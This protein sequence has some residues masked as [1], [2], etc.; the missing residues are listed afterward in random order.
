MGMCINGD[1]E[2]VSVK[3]A[4]DLGAEG[5]E[6]WKD[7]QIDSCIASLVAAL[8]RGGVDMRGSCCG[9]GRENGSIVLQDGRVLLLL[10]GEAAQKYLRHE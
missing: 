10:S 8:Q 2:K 7:C 4:S 9:H 3:I 1:T 6:K 5:I